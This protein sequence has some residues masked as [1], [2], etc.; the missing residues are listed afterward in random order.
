MAQISVEPEILSFLD[1][2]AWS[3]GT[4]D[5]LLSMNGGYDL[6]VGEENSYYP[7]ESYDSHPFAN[8]R[9]PVGT[10]VTSASGLGMLAGKYSISLGAWERISANQ[11]LSSFSPENQDKA[12]IALLVGCGAY[13][14]VVQGE[15][16]S[17]ITKAS[18]FV[19]SFPGGLYGDQTL[20][21]GALVY[22]Y[23]LFLRSRLDDLCDGSNTDDYVEPV[24]RTRSGQRK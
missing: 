19:R 5:S 15:I 12:C 14:D 7:F 8:G 17:A 21:L 22:R 3:E 13:S 23:W 11:Q 20:S 10:S 4:S 18:C 9:C 16:A 6:F 2:I 1:L 24:G